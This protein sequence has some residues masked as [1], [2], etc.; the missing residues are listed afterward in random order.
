MWRCDEDCGEKF[1]HRFKIFRKFIKKR[2]EI[3]SHRLEIFYYEFIKKIRD[4]IL[5]NQW[6]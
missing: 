6:I 1:L 5:E 2:I 3:L 4:G